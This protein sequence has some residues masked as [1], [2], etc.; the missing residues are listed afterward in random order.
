MRKGRQIDHNW[1]IRRYKG[2]CAFYAYCKCGFYY[3]CHKI[4]HSTDIFKTEIDLN[5][6]YHYCPNCGAHKKWYNDIPRKI[7]KFQWE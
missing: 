2:D 1:D 7:N 4:S 6:I 5:K 3:P